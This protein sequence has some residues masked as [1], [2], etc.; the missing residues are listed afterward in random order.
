MWADMIKVSETLCCAMSAY[1]VT[2]EECDE[3][4]DSVGSL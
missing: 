2:K 1:H 4:H 3:Y